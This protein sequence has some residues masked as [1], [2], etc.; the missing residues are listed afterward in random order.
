MKYIK[1]ISA[2]LLSLALTL[3]LA[4]CIPAQNGLSAYEIAVKNGFEGSESEWLDSLKGE[5][6]EKGD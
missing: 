6:G 1:K 3:P 4:S 2:V 5:N